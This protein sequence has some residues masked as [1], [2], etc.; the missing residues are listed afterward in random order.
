MTCQEGGC[1]VVEVADTGTGIAPEALP[2]LFQPFFTKDVGHGT[3]LSLHLSRET[4]VNQHAGSIEVT[5][6]PS[7]TRFS[8]RLP[9]AGRRK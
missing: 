5:S 8:V 6:A 9:L 3:G 1:A 4:V 7:D 2:H